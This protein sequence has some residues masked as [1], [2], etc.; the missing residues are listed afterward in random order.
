MQMSPLP[1]RPGRRRLVAIAAVVVLA[2]SAAGIVAWRPWRDDPVGRVQVEV[3]GLPEGA[4]APRIALSGPGGRRELAHGEVWETTPGVYTVVIPPV[5]HGDR[6]HYAAD[7]VGE[8]VVPVGEATA[9]ADYRVQVR[10]AARIAPQDGSPIV[11]VTETEV[12][13]ADGDYARSLRPGLLIVSGG[14]DRV[15]TAFAAMVDA[16]GPRDGQMVATVTHVPLSVALPRM[17]VRLEAPPQ[18]RAHHTVVRVGGAMPARR[19]AGAAAGDDAIT[20]ALEEIIKGRL[21]GG[22]GS[23]GIAL[24]EFEFAVEDLHWT[25]PRIDHDISWDPVDVEVGLRW[26]P[27]DVNLKSPEVRV[28]ASVEAGLSIRSRVATQGAVECKLEAELAVPADKLCDVALKVIRVGPARLACD[29]GVK[30]EFGV[31]VADTLTLDSTGGKRVRITAGFHVPSDNTGSGDSKALKVPSAGTAGVSMPSEQ[32]KRV[33]KV[34]FNAKAGPFSGLGIGL[35]LTDATSIMVK[36]KHWL[37]AGAKTAAGWAEKNGRSAGPLKVTT[38]LL[39]QYEMEAVLD[40]PDV[41]GLDDYRLKWKPFSHSQTLFE[42]TFGSDVTLDEGPRRSIPQELKMP[43]EDSASGGPPG[44]D[45]PWIAA[46]QCA[47][48]PDGTMRVQMDS[49][50]ARRDFRTVHSPLLNGGSARWQLGVYPDAATAERAYR[51]LYEAVDRCSTGGQSDRVTRGDVAADEAFLKT[52]HNPGGRPG[53]HA[54]L[55]TAVIVARVDNALVAHDMH[56]E[57]TPIRDANAAD[58]PTAVAM[59]AFLAQLCKRDWW[60]RN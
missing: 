13:L 9:A 37:A 34:E 24:D 1:P 27:I 48:D 32:R 17:V 29:M 59:R 49:D 39:Y 58:E 33:P 19:A 7:E 40:M 22:A 54:E 2:A 16:V 43:N 28:T 38:S 41:R 26:P 21:L 51:E 47:F 18:P 15:P 14:T 44:R 55:H 25:F 20:H 31:A 11:S 45:V 6:T 42:H 3:S 56:E 5:H 10:D 23:C 35:G 57:N 30:A 4:S 46:E 60:C 52:F 53:D 36:W 12:V 50:S 8:V